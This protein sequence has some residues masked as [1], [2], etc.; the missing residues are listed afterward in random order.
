MRWLRFLDAS[1][2]GIQIE[3]LDSQLLNFSLWPYTQKDLLNAGHIYE[4]PKKENYTLNI[5][6]T[7]SGV[8]DLF[9][10]IYGKAPEFRLEKGK[11]YQLGFRIR[12]ILGR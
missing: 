6:L 11:N 1:G 3:H 12:P 8:G 5:D 2:N 10:M 9:G 4:L 7:Q